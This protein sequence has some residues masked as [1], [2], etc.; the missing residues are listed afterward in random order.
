MLKKIFTPLLIILFV[1]SVYFAIDVST[2]G[3]VLAK[4]ENTE[5]QLSKEN[6]ELDQRLARQ[7]SLTALIGEAEKRGFLEPEDIIYLRYQEFTANVFTT[8]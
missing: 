8:E 5:A 4:L 2:E 3:D 6:R 7:S 1:V